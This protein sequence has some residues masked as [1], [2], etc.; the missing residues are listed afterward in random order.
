MSTPPVATRREPTHLFTEKDAV[1]QP[2]TTL[3]AVRR[4]RRKVRFWW[5]RLMENL[6]LSEPNGSAGGN[7]NRRLQHAK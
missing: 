1:R 2:G 7:P 4:M 5:P 6:A 3:D